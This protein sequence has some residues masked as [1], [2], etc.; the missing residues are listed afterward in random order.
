MKTWIGWV[1]L[2]LFARLLFAG[3]M[4]GETDVIF[5]AGFENTLDAE[6]ALGSKTAV[7]SGPAAYAPGIKGQ[8]VVLDK[9]AVLGYKTK[10]NLRGEEGTIVFWLKPIYGYTLEDTVPLFSTINDQAGLRLVKKTASMNL[11]YEDTRE[12]AN[13]ELEAMFHTKGGATPLAQFT[14]FE[15][16]GSNQW[17]MIAVSWSQNGAAVYLNGKRLTERSSDARFDETKL[18]DTMWFGKVSGNEKNGV[19]AVLDEFTVYKK[20]LSA[21]EIEALFNSRPAVPPGG[22]GP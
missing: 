20:S 17:A 12:A 16:W 14:D 18:P 6:K 13:H 4:P 11:G 8:G 2:S 19:R 22:K 1:I 3:N 5:Y 21:S 15:A 9:D 7:F 10:D